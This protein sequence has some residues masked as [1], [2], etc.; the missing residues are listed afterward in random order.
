MSAVVEVLGFGLSGAGRF[1]IGSI[2][3]KPV[4]SMSL[5][6]E[7]EILPVSDFINDVIP[8]SIM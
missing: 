6:S 2:S 7:L 3:N 8:D 1:A 4:L 5:L